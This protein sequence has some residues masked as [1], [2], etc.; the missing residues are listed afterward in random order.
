MNDS[1]YT[2]QVFVRRQWF[3]VVHGPWTV[4]WRRDSGLESWY[5]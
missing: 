2:D 1:R 4:R 3:M 5:G